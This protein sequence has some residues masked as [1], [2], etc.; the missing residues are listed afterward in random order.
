M[1]EA[2]LRVSGVV[3]GISKKLNGIS[4]VIL[5]V[6]TV[7]II[8]EIISRKFFNHGFMFVLE[9]NTYMMASAWFLSASYT[10]RTDGHIRVNL[11]TGVI[12]SDLGARILDIIATIIG[13]LISLAFFLALFQLFWGSYTMNK[14]SF[15][16]LRAPLYIPQFIIMFGMGFMLLQMVMRLLLL[17][18]NEKPDIDLKAK[19]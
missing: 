9:I 4:C 13:L 16:A 12:K 10:L 15:S 17:I 7:L 8:V 19:K 6:I 3:D 18:V 14:V 1:R 11:L 5:S 2:I